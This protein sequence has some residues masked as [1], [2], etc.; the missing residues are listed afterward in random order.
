[1][2]QCMQDSSQSLA[3]MN[4]E[5]SH[6]AKEFCRT[7]ANYDL[8]LHDLEVSCTYPL[9]SQHVTPLKSGEDVT[10]HVECVI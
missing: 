1:M 5:Q 8:L 10:L 4:G 6:K 7:F 3:V 2:I 9:V